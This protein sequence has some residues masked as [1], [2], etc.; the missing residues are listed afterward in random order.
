MMPAIRF[1]SAIVFVAS[2]ESSTQIETESEIWIVSATAVGSAE[3]VLSAVSVVF[4]SG[5]ARRPL[6]QPQAI[7]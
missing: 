3:G 5:F 7:N 2:T 6:A 4:A 1:G